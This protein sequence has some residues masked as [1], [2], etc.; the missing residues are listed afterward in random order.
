[1]TT[2][3]QS[4]FHHSARL[5]LHYCHWPNPGKPHLLLVHGGEDHNRN[6]D[7]VV[8]HL[9][10][11]FDIVAPDL[12]GHGESDWVNGAAYTISGFVLDLAN[13]VDHLGWSSLSL[14][15]HSLG[16]ALVLKYTSV[17]SERVRRV[18]AIEGLGPAPHLLEKMAGQNGASR[19]RE[20]IDSARRSARHQPTEYASRSDA[21]E[22]MMRKNAHLPA[23]LAEHLCDYGSQRLENGNYRWKHDPLLRTM[24]LFD[25]TPEQTRDMWRAITCPVLLIR[26]EESWASD[27]EAD[28]RAAFFSDATVVNIPGAGH[29]VH[30][31]QLDAF[32]A[33]TRPFLLLQSAASDGA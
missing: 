16:G 10:P 13:L 15:G 17:F 18:V 14:I 19:L 1:M 8:A 29:W 9:Q 7:R 31:D 12:R 21:L 2:T 20:W 22:R 23:E 27:P 5:R 26:G 30:H 11:H 32:M 6:W 33:A 28:G 25:I 24:P 3:P 4:R